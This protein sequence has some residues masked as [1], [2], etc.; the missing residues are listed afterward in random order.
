MITESKLISTELSPKAGACFH[1]L[2]HG[3]T[4]I[5]IFILG[6]DPDEFFALLE[7]N[8][9]DY[10]PATD[11]HAGL[12]TDAV[13]ARW[14]LLRRQRAHISFE[15]SLHE[16]APDPA[17]WRTCDLHK[18]DLFDR[19]KTQAER[20]LKRALT[21]VHH[22][23]KTALQEQ[24]WQELYQLRKQR[25][26]LERQRFELIQQ[27]V[28]ASAP[29][30]QTFRVFSEKGVTKIAPHAHSNQ[31]VLEMIDRLAAKRVTRNFI[32]DDRTVPEYQ[33]LAAA[34]QAA[35]S[36]HPLNHFELLESLKKAA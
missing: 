36:I 1:S 15:H 19:Y 14:F 20:A 10:Q 21:N 2:A 35:Q 16:S 4:A 5:K 32:F 34:E 30:A 23:R 8:F 28:A 26:E 29:A 12:V 11:E 31:R 24:H 7:S 6:E 18:L 27:K 22:I 17:S 3:G 33:W 9:Q 25:F 13:L